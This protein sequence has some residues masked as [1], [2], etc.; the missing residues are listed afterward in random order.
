M[1]GL[2]NRSGMLRGIYRKYFDAQVRNVLNDLV[3]KL[4]FAKISFTSMSTYIYKLR[5]ELLIKSN[6]LIV[7]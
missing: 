4:G 5:N 6:P 2:L 3:I 1:L 7:H